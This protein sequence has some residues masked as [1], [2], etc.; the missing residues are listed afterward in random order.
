MLSGKKI[1]LG[2]TASIA[3]YKSIILLRLLVKEG[4]EVK[5]IITPSAR[6]FISPV[7]LATFSSNKV[8]CEFDE[9]EQWENHVELGN[10]A[11]FF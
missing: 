11:D 7:I 6:K 4:A 3:A 9:N 2:I 1:L 10:W 8:Y 5:V